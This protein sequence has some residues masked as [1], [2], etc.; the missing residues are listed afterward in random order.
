LNVRDLGEA[1]AFYGGVL[2]CREGRSTDAWVDFAFFGHQISLHVG[3]PFATRPTGLIGAHA[4]PMPH[5][6]RLRPQHLLGVHRHQVAREHAGRVRQRLVDRDRRE[7]HRQTAGQT[8]ALRRKS[9]KSASPYE[10]RPL[11]CPE[12]WSCQCRIL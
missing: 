6:D 2:G 3:Q 9:E 8:K 10:V 5:F 7:F 11:S 4:V 12:S 1:R